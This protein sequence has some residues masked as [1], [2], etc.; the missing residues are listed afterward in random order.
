VAVLT[1]LSCYALARE[2]IGT[3][4]P[5]ALAAGLYLL[6]PYHVLDMYQ[7]FAISET[8][9]FVFFPLILLF[10][11]RAV[12]GGRPRDLAG[13]SLVYAGLIYT[14][15]VSALMFSLFLGLWLLWESGGRW[16]ALLPPGIAILCGFALA[17]PALLPAMLEKAHANISWVRE[18]PNGDFRIN[19]IFRDD[20]LPG[21]G[22]RD[23]VKPPVLKSAH[24]QLALAA[25]ALGLALAGRSTESRRRRRD[26]LAL[27]V[28]CALAYLLQLEISTPIWRLVPELA[29]I[30]FPWRFQTLMVLTTALLAGFAFSAAW[31]HSA[32]EGAARRQ[33]LHAGLLG[34]VAVILVNLALAGQNAYLKPF[35]YD[36][37]QNQLSR[38]VQWVE[39]AFTPVQFTLYRRFKQADVSMPRALF[40]DGRGDV[41][42]ERWTSSS[43][44]LELDSRAGGRVG[45]RTFWFPGWSASIG[46]TPLEV[47]A[48][49]P[50]GTL[51]FRVPPGRHTVELRFAATPVRRSAALVGLAAVLAMPFL[52][53]WSP[54][55]GTGAAA[56]RS[57]RGEPGG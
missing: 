30:Q 57:A 21:L 48:S 51:A 55:L 47:G 41:R 14:H 18:M 43:R 16:R 19:F 42:I 45:V 38:V 13:L 25:V 52:A 2:W 15:L 17:A 1:A 53:W 50:D 33:L 39:P 4:L 56:R 34:M 37:K 6:L 26:T 20:L 54:R 22:I 12:R 40:R 5:A 36:E 23:P 3:G 49:A 31:G 35:A 10:A 29:T 27:G 24:S 9:A 11:G 7:R 32:E 46:G 8:T 44:T 28:G